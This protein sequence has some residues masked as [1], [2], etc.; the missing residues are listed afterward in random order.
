[1]LGPTF[2]ASS[3]LALALLALSLLSF[4]RRWPPSTRRND[5]VEPPTLAVFVGAL[6]ALYEQS[7]R[8]AA[9]AVFR[10]Y[11]AGFMRRLARSWYGL[12]EVSGTRFEARLAAE[13][14]RRG[15]DGAILRG[16]ARVHSRAELTR[17]VAVLERVLEAAHGS[18]Q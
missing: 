7:G 6:A 2:I 16:D 1:V 10:A 5:D 17:A 14:A 4:A 9:D 3:T 15:P 12:G 8:R 11:H 18:K 13:A